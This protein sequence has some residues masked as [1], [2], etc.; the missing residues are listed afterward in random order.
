MA[1]G[2]AFLTDYKNDLKFAP[3][4]GAVVALVKRSTPLKD[5]P[6]YSHFVGRQKAGASE[7]D[8]RAQ[9][10]EFNFNDAEIESFLAGKGDPV[11]VSS[12]PLPDTKAVHQVKIKAVLK[13]Q[14]GAPAIYDTND[15]RKPTGLYLYPGMTATVTVPDAVVAA[16]GFRVLV[17]GSSADN[18]QSAFVGYGAQLT[19]NSCVGAGQ[20]GVPLDRVGGQSDRACGSV[21]IARGATMR[22]CMLR[23]PTALVNATAPSVPLPR[24]HVC[25]YYKWAARRL[26]RVSTVFKITSKTTTIANPLGGGIY[27]MVPYLADVGVVTVSVTGGVVEEPF[28]RKTSFDTTT[29][30]EWERRCTAFRNGRAAPWAD[31]ETDYFMMTMPSAWVYG[32]TGKEILELLERWDQTNLAMASTWGRPKDKLVRKVQ[33][34]MPDFISET[35]MSGT[36]YPMVR[37]LWAVHARTVPSRLCAGTAP[38]LT[39]AAE[40]VLV[41]PEG[42]LF[43][44]INRKAHQRCCALG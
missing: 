33:Y 29:A 41:I 21:C 17:G 20:R 37:R 43:R 30:E 5:T 3:G 32:R 10:K 13:K 25:S 40:G 19:R 12:A 44:P 23:A 24:A 35:R 9:M 31:L 7:K 38:S 2:G 15:A 16:G 6:R 28:F 11:A 8:I 14:F 4:A 18:G 34:I 1:G 27:I 36:G 22:C 26:D 39:P 42:G